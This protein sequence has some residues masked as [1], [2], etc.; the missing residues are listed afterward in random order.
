MHTY[1]IAAGVDIFLAKVDT[2][3]S[4]SKVTCTTKMSAGNLCIKVHLMI[5]NIFFCTFCGMLYFENQN[6]FNLE[7]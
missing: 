5:H 4:C 1:T 3:I 6:Y 7:I 2:E